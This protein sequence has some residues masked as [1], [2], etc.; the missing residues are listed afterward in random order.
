M[1]V[2]VIGLEEIKA[3]VGDIKAVLDENGS[4]LAQEEVSGLLS[5]IDYWMD[6]ESKA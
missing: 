1:K 2:K 3:R 6:L 5:D 4:R